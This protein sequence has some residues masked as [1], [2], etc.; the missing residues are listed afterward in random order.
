MSHQVSILAAWNSTQLQ[1][2]P[3]PPAIFRAQLGDF[4]KKN[5]F[6]NWP[7]DLSELQLILLNSSPQRDLENVDYISHLLIKTGG[8]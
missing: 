7:P 2:S 8:N 6:N 4:Q 1:R 3:S 5:D